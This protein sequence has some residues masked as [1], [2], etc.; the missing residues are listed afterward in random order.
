MIDIVSKQDCTGCMECGD[1]CPKSAIEFIEDEKGFWYPHIIAEKCIHCDICSKR[2]PSL[3]PD[4]NITENQPTVYAAWLKDDAMRVYSTSGGM[5]YAFASYIIEQGGAVAGSIYSDDWKSAHHV[6]ARNMEELHKVVG[7][8]YFQS[9]TSSIYKDVKKELANGRPFLF[10]GTP[11]QTAALRQF[12]GRDY[13][14]LYCVDFICR[15]IN[16]PLAFSSY[17]SELE[18]KH[19]S[20]ASNVHLKNKKNGWHSLASQVQF[21]NGDEEINDKTR[22]WWVKG[23]IDSDLY[24]RESCF[25]CKYKTLP[26]LNADITIGDFWNIQYQ[27]QEDEY[28][29]ISVVLVNSERGQ[30]LFNLI[31][32]RIKFQR[33]SI[34]EALSGNP[35]LLKNP[36]KSQKE[37]QFYKLLKDKGFSYAVSTCIGQKHNY[38]EEIKR[39]LRKVRHVLHIIKDP[40]IS[41]TKYIYYNYFSRN[42]VRESSNKIVPSKHVVMDLS[43]GARIYLRGTHDLQIGFNQMKGSK[44]ETQIR[45]NGNAVWNC[46]DGGWVFYD[47]VLEVKENAVLDTGFFSM[48]G[49]SV[50]VTDKH[51]TLGEDVMLGR[52]VIIYDSDFH[53]L[54]GKDGKAHN[55]PKPITIGNHVW[56]TTNVLVLK[57]TTIG[58]GCLVAGDTVLS[59]SINEENSIIAANAVGKVVKDD[60]AWNRDGCPKQ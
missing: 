34:D 52:N 47:T 36:V 17:I 55:I 30:K 22:D 7:S 10:C 58:D 60:V 44:S 5:F 8:K 16:S 2:C 26:R 35:A 41:F 24:T 49:G 54:I 23:F 3:N 25:N 59:K 38:K 46:N 27:R 51:I 31:K 28:K 33:R 43:R 21:E 57:G 42:I 56:I 53:Q 1:V 14:N 15:S 32:D 12:L 45:M 18:E 11:C 29:G 37:E 39:R 50:I 19:R 4:N 13:D 20:K 9:N 48:N 40:R 6:I